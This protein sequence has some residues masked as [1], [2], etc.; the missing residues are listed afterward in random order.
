MRVLWGESSINWVSN[1]YDFL[2]TA[3]LSIIDAWQTITF[4]FGLAPTCVL[5]HVWL[6]VTPWTVAY[7]APL[8]MEFSGQE[9]WS[10][11]PFPTLGTFLTD[12]VSPMSPALAGRLLALKLPGKTVGLGRG[13]QTFFVPLD[14]ITEF[15]TCLPASFSWLSFFLLLLW[16]LFVKQS[17]SYWELKSSILKPL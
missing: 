17:T 7:Q 9:Y 3:L 15:S 16:V 11:L 6:F 1:I 13:C 12:P 14:L 8:S 2:V 4:C 5:S 10:R